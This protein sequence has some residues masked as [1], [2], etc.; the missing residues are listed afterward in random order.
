MLGTISLA[1]VLAA[2]WMAFSGMFQGLL[3]SLGALSCVLVLWLVIRADAA[4]QQK[5]ELKVYWFAWIAYSLWL[6]KE[7]ALANYDVVCR[8][9]KGNSAID[10]QLVRLPASQKTEV[11]R[12]IYANS[13]TLT[14]GTVSV[15]LDDESVMVHALSREG[16]EAL[17]DGE[18]DR[19]V[20]AIEK[21]R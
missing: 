17:E 9:L 4:D 2:F 21:V 11:G 12:V 8:I 16:V 7:I 6:L 1:I 19:R 14:P 5:V 10:P 18:M 15:D 13:I 20:R 3:L